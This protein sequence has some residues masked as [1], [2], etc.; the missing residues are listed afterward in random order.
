MSDMPQPDTAAPHPA[1]GEGSAPTHRRFLTAA[2]LALVLYLLLVGTL[3]PAELLLGV[4]VALIAAAISLPHL[5]LL[6]GLR[7]RPLLPWYLL[8]YLASFLLALIK[9]NIDMARRV[10]APVLPICPAL[11][12]VRTDLRSPLGRLLLA[13]SITLTPGT[14]TVDVHGQRLLVHWIDARPGT[15]LDRTTRL[16]AEGFERHLKE[17]VT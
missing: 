10:V 5:G 1:P 3:D 17:F 15:A 7:L 6:D 2:G 11:V 9:A 13:N 12:E 16:I 14:L 4:A 8:R